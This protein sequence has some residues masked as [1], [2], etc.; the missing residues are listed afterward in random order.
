[1]SWIEGALVGATVCVALFVVVRQFL[2]P[3]GKPKGACRACGDV[4]ACEPSKRAEPKE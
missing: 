4:C 2:R 3:F 1:M